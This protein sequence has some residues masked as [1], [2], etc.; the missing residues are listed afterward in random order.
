MDSH[1]R[2]VLPQMMGR[3]V[4]EFILHFVALIEKEKT[5]VS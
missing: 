2:E 3:Q 5:G 4:R 1:G